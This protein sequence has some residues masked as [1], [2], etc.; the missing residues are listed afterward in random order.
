MLRGWFIFLALWMFSLA[1]P[2][3][4][5]FQLLEVMEVPHE[6]SL[7]SIVAATQKA[8]LRP[9]GKER[10]EIEDTLQARRP[11]VIQL[12]R[13]LGFI[14][15]IHPS[16]QE[17]EY[18]LILGGMLGRMETRLDTLIRLWKEGKRF[19]RCVFLV[20]ERPLD[21]TVE[22]LPC[23]T[24]REAAIYLWEHVELPAGLREL[25][26]EFLH[27]PMIQ[28]DQGMRRPTIE[29]VTKTWLLQNPKP[30]KCLAIG[31]Q[32]FCLPLGLSVQV[33]LPK[34]YCLE[35]V[36]EGVKEGELNGSVL[37]DSIARWLFVINHLSREE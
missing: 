21:P 30:G 37:L 29:D 26:I 31:N 4:P 10:W 7:D 5:I 20:S 1:A 12:A 3:Q 36:G 2:P 19:K 9:T 23:K 8:W 34:G 32:P 13:E 35:V 15:P 6:G 11:Q 28:T 24:E 17:Y 18:G 22:P 25:P 14:D 27:C 16:R 33:H